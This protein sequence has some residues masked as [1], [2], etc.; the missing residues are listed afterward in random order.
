[1]KEAKEDAKKTAGDIKEESRLWRCQI[2]G[3]ITPEDEFVYEIEDGQTGAFVTWDC[4]T[5]DCD[6]RPESVK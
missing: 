4:S 3:E 1:M 2:C 6:G 5:P